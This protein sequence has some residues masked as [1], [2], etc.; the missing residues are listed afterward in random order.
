MQFRFDNPVLVT[1]AN[2]FIGLRLV[3]R[4]A[5]DGNTIRALVLPGETVGPQMPATVDICRGDVTDLASVQAA[6]RGAGT[7]LHLACLVGDHFP[8]SAHQ[9]VT[10][11]GTENVL[12]C[13]AREKARAVL[14]S[15]IAVYG[16]AIAR[17]RC[18]EAHPH[19]AAA[20]PYSRAKQAQ[21]RVARRLAEREGLAVSIVR[22]GNVYGPG[23]TPWVHTVLDKLKSK[24]PILIGGGEF[25]AGLAYVD[26]VVDAIVRAAALPQAAGETYNALDGSDITWRRYFTDLAAAAGRGDRVR[27]LPLP[28]ARFGAGAGELLWR[29]LRLSGAPPLTREAL[30]L[31]GAEHRIPIDKARVQ[32][33]YRPEIG[34][35]QG[36][37]QVRDYVRYALGYGQGA[38]G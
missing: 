21:E 24:L 13:A 32:L 17:D 30:G 6:M 14:V 36:F 31:V 1:G 16:D 34:Y 33:G 18:D 7:V 27:S 3:R 4:L 28:V 38:D 12:G 10:V 26:N 2:G 9:R 8:D 22:P 29:L 19:G 15:S 5:A 11:Q 20:G 35:E 37:A 25:N 23:R